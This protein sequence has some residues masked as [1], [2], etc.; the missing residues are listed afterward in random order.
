[1]TAARPLQSKVC[2][3][4]AAQTD[5]QPVEDQPLS[6]HEIARNMSADALLA[7][8]REELSASQARVAQLDRQT[9]LLQQQLQQS[10]DACE[11]ATRTATRTREENAVL[12]SR[13]KDSHEEETQL[14]G[15]LASSRHD[16]AAVRRQ[17]CANQ[18]AINTLYF[19]Y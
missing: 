14:R 7:G 13:L 1:M 12:H 11:I 18:G 16:A 8:L 3:H 15:K 4:V 19:G 2:F 17:V 10:D 9:S 5:A 6:P